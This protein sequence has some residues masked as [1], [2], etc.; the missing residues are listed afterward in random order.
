MPFK[1][2]EGGRPEGA[3]NKKTVEQK[4]VEAQL[5]E[6]WNTQIP[7]KLPGILDAALLAAQ[8]GDFDPLGKLLPYIARKM[9]ETL[10][11][12][13]LA[14]DMPAKEFLIALADTINAR[15]KPS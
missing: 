14:Q 1:K 9:P 5:L 2:G 12:D 4:A 8:E 6:A 13:G 11:H 15:R 7:G 10:K 3:L